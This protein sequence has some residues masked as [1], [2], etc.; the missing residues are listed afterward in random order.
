MP[1]AP[2]YVHGEFPVRS[3]CSP[4]NL[5]P[6]ANTRTTPTSEPPMTNAQGLLRLRSFLAL[7]RQVRTTACAA[8]GFVTTTWRMSSEGFQ[9][10][11]SARLCAGTRNDSLRR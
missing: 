1:A 3:R 9:N 10:D 7:R 2:R 4:P 8:V 6:Q 11:V 5:P